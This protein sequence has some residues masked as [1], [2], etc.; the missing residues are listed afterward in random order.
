M[1]ARQMGFAAAG[2]VI[3]MLLPACGGGNPV[4]GTVSCD[5]RKGSV[6]GAEARC[7][8]RTMVAAE[9]FAIGC[10]ASGGTKG[11]GACSRADIIAGC[12]LAKDPLQHVVD[13]YYTK[14]A[15]G[16]AAERKNRE[17][18]TRACAKDGTVVDP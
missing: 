18:V 17:D 3:G 15:D 16:S 8:E 1:R 9:F 14:L 12:E 11:D 13:W 5:F 2:V 6:N 10:A 4:Y 7:Q